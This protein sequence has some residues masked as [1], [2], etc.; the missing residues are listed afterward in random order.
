MSTTPPLL[1]YVVLE[2]LQ[3]KIATNNL[4]IIVLENKISQLQKS[5]EM[6]FENGSS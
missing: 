6:E 2:E 5:L 1:K 4:K 3:K